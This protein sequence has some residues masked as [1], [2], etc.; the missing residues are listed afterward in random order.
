MPDVNDSDLMRQ[1]ADGNSE[2]AFAEL[3]RRH[4]NFV[5]SVA[6]RH[7]GNS[8][9]AQDITQAVFI[10]LARKIPGLRQRATLTGWLYETTRFT[11]RQFLR[12]RARRQAREQEAYMES[13]IHSPDTDPVWQQLAPIL[14]DAMARLSEKDRA[15]LALRFFEN[16]TVAETASLLGLNEWAVRKRAERS[17]EKLRVFFQR[18]GIAVPASVLASAISANS[19]HAAP[20]GL[21]GVVS[22]A[23]FTKGAAAST[24]T[25]TLIKGALKLMAW[26]N[27][28]IAISAGLALILVAGVTTVGIEKVRAHDTNSPAT[29]GKL[30]TEHVLMISSS[31]AVVPDS[32]LD[33]LNLHWQPGDSGTTTAIIPA[34]QQVNLARAWRRNPNVT[35]LSAPRIAFSPNPGS[36]AQGSI[37]TIPSAKNSGGKSEI[38]THVDVTASLASDLKSVGL[39][40]YTS[41]QSAAGN[42]Q[43][44]FGSPDEISTNGVMTSATVSL[45]PAQSIVIRSPLGNGSVL[46]GAPDNAAGPRSLVIFVTAGIQNATLRLQPIPSKPPLTWTNTVLIKPANN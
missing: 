20:P 23:A 10:I 1:Y 12:T 25:L 11:A 41:W 46:A 35:I 8:P 44:D 18:R 32:L 22:A 31:F 38:G 45:N 17:M 6:L 33:S 30:T 27:T 26:S 16:K 40:L 24:S 3:V 19:V 4:I 9:D 42:S 2:S 13:I 21:A 43:P 7:V 14:E 29:P 5:Y 15:L 39:K 28:K 34:S 37:S 36:V